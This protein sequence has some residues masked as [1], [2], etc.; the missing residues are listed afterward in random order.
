MA[1]S[2]WTTGSILAWTRGYF[3]DKGVEDPKIS[4][5]WLVGHAT[6]LSRLE[7]YTDFARPLASAEL[8][9][10]HESIVR[11]AEGE[12]LQYI[13]QKAPFRYLELK[14]SPGVLIPRPETE[15]LVNEVLKELDTVEGEK[16]VADVCCGSG[17]IACSLAS[18]REDINVWATDISPEAIALTERNVAA[19][20]LKDRIQ[21][22][23]GDLSAPI[24]EALRGCF[25]CVISNPPYIPTSMVDTLPEE[26]GSFEPRLALDGGADGLDIYRRLLDEANGLLRPGGILGVELHE[27]TL[28]EA[29][30]LATQ[31]SFTDTIVEKDLAGKPRVLVA[32]KG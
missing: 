24:D 30:F 28:E 22:R 21:V 31:A 25:D 13:T 32:K 5:E 7:L 3:A 14:I 8:K 9:V 2:T 15:V 18:E 20:H 19:L 17:C 6:G 11:R 23:Q 4:A 12:P 26:V 1:E 29:R 27:D 16:L 10:L